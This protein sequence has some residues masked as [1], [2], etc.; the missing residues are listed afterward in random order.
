M[1]ESDGSHQRASVFAG[2]LRLPTGGG[3]ITVRRLIALHE[4][5]QTY[6]PF[7]IY[8][9]RRLQFRMSYKSELL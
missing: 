4:L 3:G 5:I 2:G 8:H 6:A 1:H 7:D 9:T